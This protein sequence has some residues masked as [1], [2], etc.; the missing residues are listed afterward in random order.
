MSAATR[1]PSFSTPTARPCQRRCWSTPRDGWRARAIAQ[2][3]GP[4][5]D[6]GYYLLGLKAPHRRLFEDVAWSTDQV[7]AQTLARAAEIGL[8]VNVLPEWYDVDDAG[9][10]RMLCAELDEARPLPI[11]S[12]APR[13]R[14][15][16]ALMRALLADDRPATSESTPYADAPMQRA[17]E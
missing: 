1:P 6:G 10:L 9:S 3:L 15:F 14:P 11:G 5:R 13:G 8:E 7:A 2:I 4:S 12:A 17:A 16:R